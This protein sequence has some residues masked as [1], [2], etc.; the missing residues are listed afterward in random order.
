ME[1]YF[2]LGLRKMKGVNW[3]SYKEQ[4]EETVEKLIKEGLLEE[5]GEQIRLTELGIDVS[6]YVL[7]EFLIE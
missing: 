2:F 4:Y 5:D 1:E 7:A 3:M 6:N